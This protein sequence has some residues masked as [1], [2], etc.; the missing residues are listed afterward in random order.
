[1][2]PFSEKVFLRLQMPTEEV[3]LSDQKRIQQAL[4]ARGYDHAAIPLPVLQ[5][6]Y[7]MCRECGYDITVTLVWRETEWIVTAV[8][9]G[10]QRHRHYGL[11]VDYGSTTIVMQLVDLNSGTVIGQ[12]KTVNRQTDFGTDILTRITYALEDPAHMDELQRATVRSFEDLLQQLTEQTGV[13][14]GKCSVMIVS[15]NTTMIHFL[16]KLN[17]WTVFA[18]PYAPVSTDPGWFWGRDLGMAFDGLLY[19]IPAASNYIGGDIVSGLLGLEIHKKEETSL[20]FDVGTN[21]ELVLETKT[22]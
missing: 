20:F 13:D 7:P 10:D 9:P 22:G 5:Q 15:G 11:A 1:M 17:A 12:E 19:I 18:S 14:T 8:E 21:G 2:E 16:L 6:L 4:A 3:P